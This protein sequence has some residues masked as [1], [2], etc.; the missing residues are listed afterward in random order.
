LDS[1]QR[2]AEVQAAAD[3]QRLLGTLTRVLPPLPPQEHERRKADI[4]RAF[5]WRLAAAGLLVLAA[6]GSLAITILALLRLSR[7]RPPAP[8]APEAAPPPEEPTLEI[9]GSG[10]VTRWTPAAEHLY[11]YQTLEICGAS[12]SRRK[13]LAFDTSHKAKS[14]VVFAVRMSFRPLVDV[15]GK[16]KGI[17][18]ICRRR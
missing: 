11:G 6:F 18:L 14:G 8:A 9:D 15:V 10:K 16:A 13:Q 7:P 1:V 2:Q 5:R 3:R 4:M 17:G 12:V